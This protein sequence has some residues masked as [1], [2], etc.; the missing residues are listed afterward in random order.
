M[1]A[2]RAALGEGRKVAAILVAD[3]VGYSRLTSADEEATLARMRALRSELFNPAVEAHGGR[4][5]KR[6]GDG[7]I[8]EFRSVV[9]AVRCAI[10]V[11]KGLVERN[12]AVPPDRRIEVRTGIH[13]GDVVEEADG[14]LLG[15]GV[16]IAA[17]LEGI[18]EPGGICLSEDAWRQ[19]RDK[20]P[21]SFADLGEKRL[22]NIARPMRV[23]ALGG[24]ASGRPAIPPADPPGPAA[25]QHGERPVKELVRAAAGVLENV[26]GLVETYADRAAIEEAPGRPDFERRRPGPRR[27]ETQPQAAAGDHRGGHPE[28][29]GGPGVHGA[30]IRAP[31]PA[32]SPPRVG[33]LDGGLADARFAAGLS[34]LALDHR[35]AA[36]RLLAMT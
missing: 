8:V 5:V 35:V 14:D 18:S 10:E 24:A 28:R 1:I 6:M 4:V 36:S 3:V 26:G 22:K 30:A 12:A 15:D 32:P 29:A 11:T 7:V 17:R 31:P 9:E 34:L 13:L 25:A 23:F 16:N 20:I 33:A 21:E 2:E 27:K 19:V